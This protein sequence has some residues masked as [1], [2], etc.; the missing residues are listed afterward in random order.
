M[1]ASWRVNAS[2]VPRPIGWPRQ[3]PRIGIV[4]P[5]RRTTLVE[6]PASVGEHGPGER[7]MSLGASASISASVTL[8]LPAHDRVVTQLA[9]VPC[10]V[11]DEGIVVVD[12]ENHSDVARAS[13]RPRALSSVSRYPAGVRVGHDAT[14]DAEVYPTAERDRRADGTSS[15]TSGTNRLSGTGAIDRW[16]LR[17]GGI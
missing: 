16:I 10:R 4:G 6:M 17:H 9:D 13:I 8:S 12:E 3:T 1:S 11:V 7:M 5:K 14:T 2:G 15:S